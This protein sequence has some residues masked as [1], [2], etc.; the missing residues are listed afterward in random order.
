VN[1]ASVN[2]CHSTRLRGIYATSLLAVEQILC[3]S[4]ILDNIL[5]SIFT[6]LEGPVNYS[7]SRATLFGF[8]SGP[9]SRVG[10]R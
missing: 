2:Q 3:L 9:S 4:K 7:D 5:G 10:E 8:K 6:E 1:F